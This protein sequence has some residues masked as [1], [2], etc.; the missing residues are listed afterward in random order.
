M[1]FG[2]VC[3]GTGTFAFPGNAGAAVHTE[4]GVNRERRW[5]RAG[6]L[7]GTEA[8]AADGADAPRAQA[9]GQQAVLDLKPGTVLTA[10]AVEA[11]PLARTG[12]LITVTTGT[13]GISVR[14]VA[15]AMDSGTF[16]QSI[17]VRNEATKDVYEVILTGPQAGSMTG[18][19]G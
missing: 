15:R 3:G 4:A 8:A 9:V 18:S 1:T 12:Q 17:R 10:R 19:N 5:M 14:T 13:N 7:G 2:A 11:V 6:G 16:G